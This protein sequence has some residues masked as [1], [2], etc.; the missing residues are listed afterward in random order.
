MFSSNPYVEQE[1]PEKAITKRDLR[2]ILSLWT[3]PR[4]IRIIEFRKHSLQ[5]K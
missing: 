3:W 4:N 2:G 1:P 5:A